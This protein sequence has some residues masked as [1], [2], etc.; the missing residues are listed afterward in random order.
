M[1]A[2]IARP[3]SSL[4]HRRVS[5]KPITCARNQNMSLAS[6]ALLIALLGA[7][8]WAHVCVLLTLAAHPSAC[9]YTLFTSHLIPHTSPTHVAHT[10]TTAPDIWAFGCTL[11]EVLLSGSSLL[12]PPWEQEEEQG[13]GQEAELKKRGL[14]D[15]EQQLLGLFSYLGTP[16]WSEVCSMNSR[17]QDDHKRMREWMGIAPR[18]PSA[19]WRDRII[20]A[21][22]GGD[23]SLAHEACALL[24]VIFQWN[25]RARPS[26]AAL[27]A[28]QFF[29]LT[30]EA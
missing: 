11:G 12:A 9:S 5:T 27:S 4:A 17:L 1:R 3:S 21:D 7:V 10:D 26:A 14:G 28:H 19:S 22:R 13:A 18:P 8:L 20:H 24:S 30:S 2:T 25:P 16:S 29:K 15:E 6:C 23:R